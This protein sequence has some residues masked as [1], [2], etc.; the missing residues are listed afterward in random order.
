M[1]KSITKHKS[2]ISNDVTYW[3][4]NL[5]HEIMV[6]ALSR[7]MCVPFK[8]LASDN[9]PNAIENNRTKQNLLQWATLGCKKKME[10]TSLCY[11]YIRSSLLYVSFM[12]AAATSQN[13]QNLSVKKSFINCHFSDF[14]I[15]LYTILILLMNSQLSGDLFTLKWNVMCYLKN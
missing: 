3:K 4:F 15:F 14:N 5:D 6:R 13:S 1:K 2:F 10:P 9:L 12:L 11:H 8:D 7:F